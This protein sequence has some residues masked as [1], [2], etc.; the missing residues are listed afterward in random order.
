MMKPLI[1][2]AL[3]TV[4]STPQAAG[5]TIVQKSDWQ[6]TRFESY[7][8]AP[9]AGVPWLDLDVRTRLPKRDFPVGW[10]AKAVSPFGLHPIPMDAQ[11]SSIA[12]PDVGRM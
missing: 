1:A 2:A 7:L 11:V 8:P 9:T 3:A 6:F 12:A 5:Q 4:L 10:H